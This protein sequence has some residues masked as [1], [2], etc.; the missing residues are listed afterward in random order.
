MGSLGNRRR[1]WVLLFGVSG[2]PAIFSVILLV[3][4]PLATIPW[5][6]LTWS[7]LVVS[8][9]RIWRIDHPYESAE[10]TIARLLYLVFSFT[11]GVIGL[12]IVRANPLVLV[13][14]LAA[15]F[16]VMGTVRRRP[17]VR[18]EGSEIGMDQR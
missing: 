15:W 17:M 5:L 8:G 14:V 1:L 16:V 3:F 6:V 9:Y 18:L 7:V 2:L 13:V 4:D 11:A 12:T 10:R